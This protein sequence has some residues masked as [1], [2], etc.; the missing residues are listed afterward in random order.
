MNLRTLKVYFNITRVMIGGN[1]E[2][3]NVFSQMPQT[4]CEINSHCL[5]IKP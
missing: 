2:I 4:Y 3:E 5:M 1:S